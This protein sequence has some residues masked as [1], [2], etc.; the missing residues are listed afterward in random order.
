MAEE[1]KA[2]IIRRIYETT[3]FDPERGTYRAVVIRVEYPPGT[4]HDITIPKDE[5]NP[6]K[7]PD[8]VKEWLETYGQWVGKVIE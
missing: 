3:S 2:P 5:F 4:F 1:V 6:K 7:V 8:Y